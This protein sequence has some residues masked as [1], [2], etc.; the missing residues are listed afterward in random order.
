MIKLCIFDLDGTLVNSIYDLADS[1]NYS[2]KKNGLPVHETEKYRK[3][4]GSGI[5]VLADRVMGLP[6]GSDGG[7]LK[8]AVLAGFNEYYNEHCLDKTRPYKGIPELLSSLDS[9]GIRYAVLSNKPDMFSKRIIT[10]LFPDNCFASVMGKREGIARKPSPQAVYLMLEELDV[11][12]KDCL[13]I[14]DSDVDMYTARNAGVASCGVSWGFRSI[15][16]LKNAG[17]MMIAES[18]RDVLTFAR[19]LQR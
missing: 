11:Q 2:L 9:S 14:G 7:E 8:K 16:E 6:D 3:M 19:Q 5:S 15:S 10:A 4:V 1:M 18:P 13:Y 17:A 12:K